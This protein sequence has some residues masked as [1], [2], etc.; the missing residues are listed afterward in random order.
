VEDPFGVNSN[1]TPD[2]SLPPAPENL[3][4]SFSGFVAEVN[5]LE[6]PEKKKCK[7]VLASIIVFLLA[8]SLVALLFCSICHSGKMNRTNQT[9][10]F[11]DKS[12]G[13]DSSWTCKDTLFPAVKKKC[14]T[15]PETKVT[16]RQGCAHNRHNDVSYSKWTYDWPMLL[17]IFAL[18]I[19]V[20]VIVCFYLRYVRNSSVFDKEREKS[21]QEHKQRLIDEYVS[22][23]LDR[24]RSRTSMIEKQYLY[25]QQ[26]ALFPMETLQREQEYYWKYKAKQLDVKNDLVHSFC[27]AVKSKR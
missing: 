17:I 9:C 21:F 27:D 10:Q 16:D 12:I 14:E 25:R 11:E 22:V 2:D 5:N 1:Q 18:I 20:T 6:K 13:S 26:R 19:A 4:D 24:E 8:A 7:F 3:K 15:K 23:Q